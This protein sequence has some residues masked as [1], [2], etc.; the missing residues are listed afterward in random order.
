MSTAGLAK[1]YSG[2]L[3]LDVSSAYGH[4]VAN[5]WLSDRHTLVGD[6]LL[7][8]SLAGAWEL[9]DWATVV[10]ELLAPL[11][12]V[13]AA[14]LRAWC[15]AACMFHLGIGFTMDIWFSTNVMVYAAFLPWHRLAPPACALRG[16]TFAAMALG[17]ALV[18]LA[19][20][21]PGSDS[22]WL[23]VRESLGRLVVLGALPLTVYAR[24]R[25]RRPPTGAT[26]V[27]IA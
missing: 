18:M 13:R 12:I 24:S 11:V 2:W 7:Q 3:R 20:S 17:F 23:R 4:G 5:A 21:A 1:L 27:R 9:L 26:A 6:L 19:A 14:W 25:R 16:R 10:V 22:P 8:P 15:V